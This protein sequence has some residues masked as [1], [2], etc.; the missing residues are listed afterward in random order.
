[1]TLWPAEDGWPYPDALG[2]FVDVAGEAD[3]DLLAVRVDTH[4]FDSLS[5]L[6]REVIA[7]RFGLQGHAIR[8]INELHD[9]LGV[10]G[11][12]LRL[13]YADGLEKLRLHLQA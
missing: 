2:D 12:D 9:E 10:P 5:E 7:A 6:E 3:D 4:L 1:M 13:A 8:T 11:D